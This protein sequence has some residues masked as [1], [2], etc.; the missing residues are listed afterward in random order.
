MRFRTLSFGLGVLVGV[1]LAFLSAR[2][3]FT[4]AGPG[5]PSSVEAAER[6]SQTARGSTPVLL[7]SEAGEVPRVVPDPIPI[8]LGEERVRELV[9]SYSSEAP[10]PESGQGEITGMVAREDGSALA[11]VVIEARR[12]H[13]YSKTSPREIGQAAPPLASLEEIVTEAVAKHRRERSG[14]FRVTSDAKGAYLFDHLPAGH[15]QIQ[16]YAPDYIFNSLS[17]STYDLPLGS[18]VD[19]E[20][21]PV[22]TIPV[23]VLGSQGEPVEAAELIAN[24]EDGPQR[25]YSWTP[26]FPALRLRPGHYRIEAGAAPLSKSTKRAYAMKSEPV[27]IALD[28]GV[29]PTKLVLKL[30]AR[31]GIHGR[32]LLPSDGLRGGRTQVL[33]LGLGSHQ[34][35]DLRLLS[36][37]GEVGSLRNGSFSFL[38]LEPG[39]Y[40][41]GVASGRGSGIRAHRVV[42]V[43][44]GICDATIDVPPLDRSRLLTVTALDPAG[45]AL[46]ELDFR[47]THQLSSTGST[48]STSLEALRDRERRHLLFLRPELAEIYFSNQTQ[49]HEFLL[50]I[51]HN[52]YGNK[53]V[54]LRAGQLELS[55]RFSEAAEVSVKVLGYS[56]SDC[57][58]RVSLSIARA[59]GDEIQMS[60]HEQLSPNGTC[61]IESLEAGSYRLALRLRKRE[62]LSTLAAGHE[63]LVQTVELGTGPNEVVLQLPPLFDLHVYHPEAE[64][65]ARLSVVDQ[66]SPWGGARATFDAGGRATVTEI[67]AG[68][69]ELH[70]HEPDSRLRV[71]V[72]CGEVVFESGD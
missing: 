52:R 18:R 40:V 42:T 6:R 5:D 44:E 48:N 68:A 9:S 14:S 61:R 72:P 63:I 15:W 45:L 69:Y 49:G 11:G 53:T 25:T 39:R 67:P 60:Q 30:S 33:L 51:F 65:G 20:A 31:T 32:V 37:S 19:F 2:F 46:A 38:D 4:E 29:E 27:E 71:E 17:G 43:S 56:D 41:V 8:D 55:V 28:E 34:E 54:P 57:L 13:D 21:W 64:A 7:E 62:E 3:L 1:G 50:T 58:G 23:E 16:A 70:C 24:S 35:V 47:L 36:Q 59:L 12:T 22:L 66:D 10:E 26:D